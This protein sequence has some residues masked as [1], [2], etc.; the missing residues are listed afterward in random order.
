MNI[1]EQT[2][3]RNLK[4]SLYYTRGVCIALIQ[5]TVL[6]LFKATPSKYA[7]LIHLR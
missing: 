4:Q 7:T 5:S 1:H 6:I 3:Y 2:V